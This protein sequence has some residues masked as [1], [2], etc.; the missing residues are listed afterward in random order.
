MK[1]YLLPGISLTL[2]IAVTAMLV[3]TKCSVLSNDP[4]P[5]MNCLQDVPQLCCR[6]YNGVFYARVAL[7][8]GLVFTIA[9]WKYFWPKHER[10]DLGLQR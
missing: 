4:G 1:K 7:I 6:D 5:M 10:I 9:I 3:P 8:A 2:T